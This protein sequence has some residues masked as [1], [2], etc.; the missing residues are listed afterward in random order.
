MHID[1]LR[2]VLPRGALHAPHFVPDDGLTY[3]TIH[4][5]EVQ[6]KRRVK[7][8]PCGPG[9]VIH[10]YVS[11]YFGYLSPMLLK[12]KSGRVPG[13]NEGQHPLIYLVSSAQAIKKSGRCFVF[14]DGHGIAAYTSWFDDLGELE[15][16]DWNMVYQRYWKDEINDMDRQ[17][18][19]QAEFLVHRSCDWSL[20]DQI[21][22]VDVKMKKRVEDIL[23]MFPGGLHRPVVVHRGWYY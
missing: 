4:D 21:V 2:V 10:D 1:S 14:S 13:Y 20:I 9:G 22:V 15:K 19:K 11:F 17:R 7:V 16:V 8:I 6:Q 12:L 18:R 3:L 5:L 23:K